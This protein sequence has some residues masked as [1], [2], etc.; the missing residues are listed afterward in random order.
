MPWQHNQVLF[1]SKDA[2]D[3]CAFCRFIENN[4]IA[5]ISPY[6]FRGLKAL[7]HLWV[8]FFLRSI[9]SNTQEPAPHIPPFLST[10]YNLLYYNN[11]KLAILCCPL[12]RGHSL[13]SNL[14]SMKSPREKLMGYLELRVSQH[15]SVPSFVCLYPCQCWNAQYAEVLQPA[16]MSPA[17][18]W[19][20][21]LDQ[22]AEG[23]IRVSGAIMLA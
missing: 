17:P 7:I 3:K 2:K 1:V 9:Q 4:R 23:Q 16:A 19:R 20:C 11:P 5:T 22:V 12:Q 8:S 15:A 13:Y 10:C 18:G 21:Q 14:F 6:A